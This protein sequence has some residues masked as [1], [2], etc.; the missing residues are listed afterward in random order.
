M[1]RFK[2]I[3]VYLGGQLGDEQA[4]TRASDLAIANGARLT[5]ID[6]LVPTNGS[7]GSPFIPPS[8]DK[9]DHDRDRV[10]ERKAMLRRIGTSHPA[11]DGDTEV[12]VTLGRPFIEIVKKV[13]SGNHDLVV[14]AADSLQ[15]VRLIALGATSMHLMRK[16]PCPVWVIKPSRTPRFRNVLAAIDAADKNQQGQ[17]LNTKILQLSSSIARQEQ[18]NFHISY[19][20]RFSGG[21]AEN[22]RSEISEAMMDEIYKRNYRENKALVLNA[23]EGIE[24]G[25]VTPTIHLPNGDPA[26]V[27]PT[28]AQENDIDLIVM[29][30]VSRSGISGLLMGNTAEL[31]LRQVDCSVLTAKPDG[32][33]TPVTL[34]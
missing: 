33:E 10:A 13:L 29:G 5:L 16:C 31:V 25:N 30:S 15:G 19:A 21:D 20:W 26:S 23:L 6:V 3:L 18:C 11:G 32:F 8:A 4:L 34:D 2:N 7:S 9:C 17:E 24:L 14:M 12:F 28:V 27:V 22:V 1:K